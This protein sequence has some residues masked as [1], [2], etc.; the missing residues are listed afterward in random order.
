MPITLFVAL[1]EIVSHTSLRSIRRR[2]S[3]VEQDEIGPIQKKWL[4]NLPIPTTYGTV[5]DLGHPATINCYKIVCRSIRGRPEMMSSFGGSQ[6]VT[7]S[8]RREGVSPKVTELN[9]SD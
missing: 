7:K 4:P 9:K 2:K 8:D 6:K 3:Q 1:E 5:D